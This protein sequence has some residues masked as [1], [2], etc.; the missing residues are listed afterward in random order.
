[1]SFMQFLPSQSLKSEVAS[2]EVLEK[3]VKL[4]S[5]CVFFTAVRHQGMC[6]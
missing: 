1:M 6:P 2:Q 3:C 4:V 5:A